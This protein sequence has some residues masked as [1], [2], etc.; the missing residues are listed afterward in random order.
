MEE[1]EHI[2]RLRRGDLGGLEGLVR[3]HQVQ[4]VRVAYLICRDRPLAEDIVQSAFVRAYERIGQF[5]PRRPFGPWFLRSVAND[6][7]K[8]AA[9]R[10]RSVSLDTD[11]S[12]GFALTVSNNPSPDDLLLT[13]ETH[14]AIMAALEKL[15]P[16][17]RAA[18]VLRYYLD[19]SEAEMADQLGCPPGTVKRRLFDARQR[20]RHLLPTWVA[21]ED[22]DV[23]QGDA[24][25]YTPPRRIR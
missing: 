25:Y 15:T 19:L 6:A 11:T 21:Q 2:A 16:R 5:D 18:I 4:A 8:A 7:L 20:L 9:Q 17:Q 3:A 14:E 13:G 23:Q 12:S 1:R 22:D 10:E 24:R